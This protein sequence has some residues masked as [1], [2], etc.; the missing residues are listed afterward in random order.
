MLEMHYKNKWT[1][2]IRHKYMCVQFVHVLQVALENNLQLMIKNI[3]I[4]S[5][6]YGT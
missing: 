4:H 2:V 5:R 3:D 6:K 1:S